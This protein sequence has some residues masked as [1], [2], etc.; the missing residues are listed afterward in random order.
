MHNRLNKPYIIEMIETPKE[1]HQNKII[2][3]KVPND[4]PSLYY[5]H[6]NFNTYY[7]YPLLTFL[8]ILDWVIFQSEKFE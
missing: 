2:H 8:N 6:S 4:H 7:H 3:L 5:L 1:I